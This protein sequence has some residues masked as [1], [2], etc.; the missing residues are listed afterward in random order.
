[1]L[2]QVNVG[3]DNCLFEMDPITKVV[4]GNKICGPWESPARAGL[5]LRDGYLL[6][7]RLNDDLLY[8][9]DSAGNLLDSVYVGLGIAGLAYNP[10]TRHLFAVTQGANPWDVWVFEPQADY[11]V[12]GGF[13]VTDGG[14]PILGFDAPARSRLRR[15]PL[16][17]HDRFRHRL[18]FESGETGW[19]VNDIP[20]L[21]ETPRKDALSLGLAPGHR[22]VRLIRPASRPP[23]GLAHLLD[24]Y[25]DLVAPVPVDF[26]VLFN[27]VPQ[28][29]FAWNFIYGAAGAGVMPGC[30]PQTPTF[31]FCPA[32]VVTR[33]SMAGFIERAI[34]GALTPPPVYLNGF[35]D[36]F[37]GSFN[38]NY[39]QGLVDDAITAGC[40]VSPPLY[41]PDTPVTRAQ[42]AVF[43][44]KALLVSE[45]PPACEGVFADVPC[46]SQFADYI[47]GIYNEGIT[48]G[49]G[50]DDVRPDPSITNAQ[51]A[52][53]LVKAF[54]LAYLVIP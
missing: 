32:E 51:M 45:P 7:R 36:V 49:C 6:R 37:A 29:S 9:L 15:P 18:R 48:A 43:M 4:T 34:H 3:G 47:E 50:D 22:L 1:M 24:G 10:T 8:H 28:G 27:D 14:V 44:W 54:D 46:P 40:S 30:A 35:Q 41:C 25:A 26:T 17:Q 16:A 53:F 52:V 39:I 20:W 2:W 12:L 23:A 11:A 19:C 33:R 13:R 21:S 42:M 31:N 5:R 38:A